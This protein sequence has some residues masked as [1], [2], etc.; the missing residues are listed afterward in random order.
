VI[1]LCRPPDLRRAKL[2]RELL[3]LLGFENEQFD[4]NQ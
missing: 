3:S 4:L 2:G 1:S